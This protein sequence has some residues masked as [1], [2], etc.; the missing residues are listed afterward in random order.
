MGARFLSLRLWHPLNCQLLTHVDLV[1][2]QLG[3][4]GVTNSQILLSI[5]RGGTCRRQIQP[6]VRQDSILP[7]PVPFVVHQTKKMLSYRIALLCSTQVQIRSNF[8][9]LRNAKAVLVSK[10]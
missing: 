9:R 6:L 2:R 10:P 1:L 3:S 7:N 5:P 8:E 4:S